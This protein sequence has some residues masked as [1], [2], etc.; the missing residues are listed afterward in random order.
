MLALVAGT[1]LAAQ[2]PE[3]SSTEKAATA[4]EV[5]NDAPET[6]AT[7][8]GTILSGGDNEYVLDDGSASIILDCGPAWYKVVTLAVGRCCDGHRRAREEAQGRQQDRAGRLQSATGPGGTVTVRESGGRPPWAGARRQRAGLGRRP[9]RRLTDLR[10]DLYRC[11]SA[12]P[13]APMQPQGSDGRGRSPRPSLLRRRCTLEVRAAT[14]PRPTNDLWGRSCAACRRRRGSPPQRLWTRVRA[15]R[16]GQSEF[17]GSRRDVMT[18]LL[19]Q[20]PLDR[21]PQRR[22]IRV[23][24]SNSP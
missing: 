9:R 12:T 19:P 2:H 24:W 22:T 3:A 16:P 1:A 6:I 18:P 13:A 17:V 14:V 5:D 20:A 21:H 7:I 11:R 10:Q 8:S 23:G 15:D 4:N